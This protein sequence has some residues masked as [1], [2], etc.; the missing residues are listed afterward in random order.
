MNNDTNP[1]LHN[2]VKTALKLQEQSSKKNAYASA[3]PFRRHCDLGEAFTLAE[4]SSAMLT[5]LKPLKTGAGGEIVPPSSLG[6]HGLEDRLKQPDL[7]DVDVTIKR[8]QLADEAGVFEMA[9]ETAESVK[10]KGSIQKMLSHQL[11]G[12]HHHAMRLLGEADKQRDP[13]IKAKLMTTS[14]R[15][16]EAFCKGALTLQKLQMGASQIVTVQHVQIHGGQAIIGN[17]GHK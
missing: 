13:M 6:Y 14:T 11:A 12:A 4:R 3:D 2:S 1:L 9:I 10:A 5:P 8:T 16:M 15:L 17:V 7:L